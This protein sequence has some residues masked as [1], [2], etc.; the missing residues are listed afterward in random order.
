M[1]LVKTAWRWITIA[2]RGSLSGKITSD[3]NRWYLHLFLFQRFMGQS[4][5]DKPYFRYKPA[6]E[7][8]PQRIGLK[9][10]HKYFRF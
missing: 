10:H 4:K 3:K 8:C 9:F 6:A 1:R 7:K 5:I 2:W